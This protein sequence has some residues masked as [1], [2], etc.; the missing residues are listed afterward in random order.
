MCFSQIKRIKELLNKEK[1]VLLGMTAT[2]V[3]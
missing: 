1:E 2:V 3:D